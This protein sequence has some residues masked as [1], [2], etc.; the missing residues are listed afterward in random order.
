[1]APLLSNRLFTVLSYHHHN[2]QTHLIFHSS[3]IRPSPLS[4]Q[5]NGSVL[6]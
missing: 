4:G 3:T 2:T 5:F 6:F 1:M